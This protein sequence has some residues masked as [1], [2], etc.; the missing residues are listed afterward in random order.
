MKTSLFTILIGILSIGSVNASNDSNYLKNDN[1]SAKCFDENTRIL[2]VGVGVGGIRHYRIAGGR[3]RETPAFSIS[4]EQPWKQRLGPGYIGVGGYLG[5]QSANYRNTY[6]AP[7]D[8]NDYYYEH[9]W[10]NIL[11]AGRAAY[12]WD[13][14]NKERAE[15]YGGIIIGAR[16]QLYRYDTNDPKPEQSNYKLKDGVA[17]P[18]YSLFAGARWYFAKKVGVFA[19]AGY[20]ISYLTAGLTFKI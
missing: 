18:T 17:Y 7:H 11:V 19:E 2:N 16:I 1:T 12:H 5:F 15:V 4:Y 13:V 14:L 9:H 10:N 20:G 6:R 8:F 3:Y